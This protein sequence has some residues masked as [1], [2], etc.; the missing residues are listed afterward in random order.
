MRTVIAAGDPDYTEWLR[1]GDTVLWGQANAEPL[2]L[3]RALVAQRHALGR[4]R[5]ILGIDRAGT[6][7]PEN[8]DSFDLG[9]IQK[10]EKNRTLERR[11]AKSKS[12]VHEAAG[13]HELVAALGRHADQCRRASRWHGPARWLSSQSHLLAL[14]HCQRTLGLEVVAP[15]RLARPCAATPA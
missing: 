9:S 15:G 7:L 11:N 3:T 12:P 1:P 13:G 8:A 14:A 5:L 6:V 10:T 2:T 4:L